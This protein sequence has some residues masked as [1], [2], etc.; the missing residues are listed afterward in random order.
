MER[1]FLKCKGCGKPWALDVERQGSHDKYVYPSAI[2]EARNRP[3]P[4][5]GRWPNAGQRGPVS[6]AAYVAPHK[7]MGRVYRSRLVDS[8]EVPPC[9]GRCTSA[10]GPSC[11]CPCDGKNHGSNRVITINR[12]AGPIPKENRR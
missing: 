9:D 6:M 8:A 2:T 7:I 11:D 1:W 5:C 10:R 12:N 3:C 4:F